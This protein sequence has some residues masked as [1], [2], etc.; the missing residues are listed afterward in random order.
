MSLDRGICDRNCRIVVIRDLWIRRVPRASDVVR[1][2]GLVNHDI[3]R[4]I[5]TDEE[6]RTTVVV[7]LI[8]FNANSAQSERHRIT[9][10]VDGSAT[11][12]TWGTRLRWISSVSNGV[13][14]GEET[15]ED[16]PRNADTAHPASVRAL[17]TIAVGSTERAVYDVNRKVVVLAK[18]TQPRA[19]QV[20]PGWVAVIVEEAAIDDFHSTST[21]E[22]GTASASLF[23]LPRRVSFDER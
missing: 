14:V 9:I 11:T 3:S 15:V 23:E 10:V 4:V 7:D 12:A 19:A 21:H 13:I 2:H 18:D 22:N 20:R 6:Y 5:V 1:N 8:V 16:G 17:V